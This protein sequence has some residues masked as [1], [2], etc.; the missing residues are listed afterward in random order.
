MLTVM[1]WLWSQPGGRATYTAAQVNIWA[2]MVRRNLTLPHRIACVTDMPEGIDHD[3][4]IIEPPRDFEDVQIPTWTG[5]RPQCLR[6]VAMFSP[7]AGKLFGDRFVS[8]DMDC[9]IAGSLDPLFS[10]AED[11]VLYESPGPAPDGRPYNGSM[12]MMTAGARPQVYQDFTPEGAVEAGRR[13]AGSDLAW[14]SYVL[15]KG[16]AVWNEEDGVVWWGR[17]GHADARLM[18]FPGFPKPWNLIGGHAWVSDHYRRNPQGKALLLGYDP[19]VWSD[20][21]KAM[22]KHEF[23]AVIASPEAAEHWPG[24]VLAVA[25]DDEHAEVL[26]RMHGYEPIWCGKSA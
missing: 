9:V 15:G 24:P 2:D 26:A 7:D 22:E 13:Y 10:R 11:I 1:T 6:R 16:E 20:V 12:L 19:S 3:I 8:M 5:G 4:A 18:F 23:D 25:R 17:R 14:I 21:E